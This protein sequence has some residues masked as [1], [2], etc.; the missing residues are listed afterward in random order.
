MTQVCDIAIIF[1][2]DT[3]L[4]PAV[5]TIARACRPSHIETVSWRHPGFKS[6]LKQIAGVYHHFLR[7][8]VFQRVETPINYAYR[9]PS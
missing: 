5:E 3:D 2:H 1:S 8:D 4:A 9:G 7:E 6:R